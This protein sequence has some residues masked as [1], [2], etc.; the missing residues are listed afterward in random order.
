LFSAIVVVGLVGGVTGCGP[1]NESE[2]KKADAKLGDP[3]KPTG[4]GIKG[5]PVPTSNEERAKYATQSAGQGQAG[6]P[7]GSSK[8]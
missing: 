3:G 4:E 2:G 5:P 7:G 8:K 6:Y 1:D